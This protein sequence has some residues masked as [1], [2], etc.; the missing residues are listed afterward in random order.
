MVAAIVDEVRLTITLWN[1]IPKKQ[2]IWELI[3]LKW[4]IDQKCFIT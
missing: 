3:M 4:S 1:K 2:E